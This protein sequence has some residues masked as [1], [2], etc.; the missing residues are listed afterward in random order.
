MQNMIPVGLDYARAGIPAPE[1][2]ATLNLLILPHQE[3]ITLH[4]ERPMVIVV[5]GGAYA[6]CSDREAEAIALKFLAEGIHAAVL[7]PPSV[8]KARPPREGSERYSTLAASRSALR[9]TSAFLGLM[10]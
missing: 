2:P 3:E 1:K 6:F 10:V 5:P 9:T 7:R 8:P 4:P